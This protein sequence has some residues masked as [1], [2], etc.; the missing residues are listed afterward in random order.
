M[1]HF[2]HAAETETHDA[3]KSIF[4]FASD[5]GITPDQ[6]FDSPE[7]ADRVLDAFIAWKKQHAPDKGYG[8]YDYKPLDQSVV[9]ELTMNNE[10]LRPFIQQAE[11]REFCLKA[12]LS[13]LNPIFARAI[14]D[15]EAEFQQAQVMVASPNTQKRV[16]AVS[17]HLSRLAQSIAFEQRS[18]NELCSKLG[19]D[20]T[21]TDEGVIEATRNAI[22]ERVFTLAKQH[23]GFAMST[24]NWHITGALYNDSTS[25]VTSLK[26][27]IYA[28]AQLLYGTEIPPKIF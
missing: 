25:I 3:F 23:T 18:K 17:L 8:T 22:R 7:K 14:M 24:S 5:S 19:I 26:R 15:H 27:S 2:K 20:T 10:S 13:S 6:A 1:E 11:R 21:A 9:K 16:F 4:G 28:W 12:S